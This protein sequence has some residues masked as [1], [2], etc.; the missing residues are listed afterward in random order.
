MEPKASD[1]TQTLYCP[2]LERYI[3]EGLCYDMQMILD[4]YIKK[5]ALPEIRIDKLQLSECC[6][7][8]NYR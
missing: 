6:S 2:Y 8:C 7:K 5:P 4:G 1:K 3:D